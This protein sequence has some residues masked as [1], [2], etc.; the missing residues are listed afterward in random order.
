MK[1]KAGKAHTETQ[2]K[3]AKAAALQKREGKN[4]LQMTDNREVSSSQTE[5]QMMIDHSPRMA[6]QR[7]QLE[8]SFDTPV[9]RQG[10][11]TAQ[12]AELED[13]ELK[14]GT[15]TAQRTE[16]KTGLPDNLKTGIENLSG[17][18]LDN[19][20]VHSNSSKP[21]TVG[22]YAYTQGTDIHVAPGQMKHLPHEA[23]HVVQQI[24]G[25]VQPTGEIAGL[26]VND[27]AVLEKEADIFGA[28]AAD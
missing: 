21:A 28:K 2:E 25:R 16:N 17:L 8:R 20:R 22:A 5:V 3:N 23:W 7:K 27:S 10:K 14:Q 6:V 4:N 24:Q 11:F 9:Q 26:P 13:E 12:R 19:V 1:S 18:S 15:F